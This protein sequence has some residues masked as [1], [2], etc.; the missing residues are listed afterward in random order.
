MVRHSILGLV[1]KTLDCEDEKQILIYLYVTID[2]LIH[3]GFILELVVKDILSV[4]K[5]YG[6]G[7]VTMVTRLALNANRQLIN[8]F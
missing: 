6:C 4:G 2:I 8:V 5:G 7:K 1:Q 3:S